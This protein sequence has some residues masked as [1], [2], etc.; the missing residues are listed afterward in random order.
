MVSLTLLTSDN[1]TLFHSAKPT[2]LRPTTPPLRFLTQFASHVSSRPSIASSAGSDGVGAGPGSFMLPLPFTSPSLELMTIR[3]FDRVVLHPSPGSIPF[4][5][6]AGS[7]L[8]AGARRRISKALVRVGRDDSDKYWVYGGGHGVGGVVMGGN[9]LTEGLQGGLGQG[10]VLATQN[11][12]AFR[13]RG[14]LQTVGVGLR[15]DAR[16]TGLRYL[17]YTYPI[18]SFLLFT[19]LFLAFEL[20][21][22]LTLWTIAAVYTSSLPGLGVDLGADNQ[23]VPYRDGPDLG[24]RGYGSGDDEDE[25][26]G[27][28]TPRRRARSGATPETIT[29]TP[30][31]TSNVD[32]DEDEEAASWEEEDTETEQGTS[33]GPAQLR[34]RA[35]LRDRDAEEQ[36]EVLLAAEEEARRTGRLMTAV[37]GAGDAGTRPRA[38]AGAGAEGDE[39]LLS[40]TY[41]R[42]LGRLDEETEEETDDVASVS[43]GMGSTLSS[44]GTGT[45][46]TQRRT[47][48]TAATATAREA[49]GE[50]STSGGSS[51]RTG[52]GDDEWEDEGGQGDET[53]LI[54]GGRSRE[55]EETAREGQAIRRR[56]AF[57]EDD[58]EGGDGASTIGGVSRTREKEKT[59]PGGLFAEQIHLLMTPF[60]PLPFI[61]CLQSATD[62]SI[63]SGSRRSF[64]ATTQAST[65]TRQ[66]GTTGGV[67]G[68]GGRGGGSDY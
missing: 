46:G 11:G 55:G 54:E 30:T 5:D 32:E 43:S 47:A 36:R 49:S 51:A 14:E 50:S 26:D 48:P 40:P 12:G 9:P 65:S 64:G 68:G 2:I 59:L 16:L 8:R 39:D 25:D 58:D 35:S 56:K 24:G 19:S 4:S 61:I 10:M 3:L 66:T 57:E 34:S 33:T 18:L 23:F 17:L 62:P 1:V 45:G 53:V 7:P 27:S 42:V 63:A 41:R 44:S 29:A 28:S 37:A 60:H 20:I 38:A 13:S 21:S 31:T 67:G 52:E 6:P 22:A 15:F